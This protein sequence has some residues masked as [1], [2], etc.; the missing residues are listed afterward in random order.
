MYPAVILSGGLASRMREYTETIPKAM[1][2]IAGKPFIDRQLSMLKTQ[3]VGH[4][5][6]CIGHLGEMIE[7]YAGDG[8]K[9]GLKLTYSYD[10]DKLLGTGGAVKKIIDILPDTFFVLYG[11]SYLEIPYDPLVEAFSSSDKKGLMTVY[12]N[13]D[14]YDASNVIFQNGELIAYRKH[15]KT[16]EMRHIDYGLGI[17]R[18]EV[19]DDFPPDTAF[20]LA[21]IYEKLVNEKELLGF[22][23]FKRFYE[24]GSPGGLQEL[25]RKFEG[26]IQRGYNNE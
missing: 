25:R 1:L 11:D 10:G 4:V 22:E 20:D 6:L 19:F 14:L 23:V 3:G 13:A 26:D 2:D 18:K 7:A 16:D 5:F 21:G 9:Y 24:I 15:N 8:S 12:E 17:L